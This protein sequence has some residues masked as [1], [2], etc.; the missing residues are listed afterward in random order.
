MVIMNG[1]V[2]DGAQISRHPRTGWEGRPTVRQE[3]D[4]V[5]DRLSEIEK[6]VGTA[7]LHWTYG[8]HD[9]RFNSRL[10]AQVAEFEGVMGMNL[11]DHFPRW[12]FSTSVMVNGSTHIKHR[13]HSGIH[14]V[15]N[16][17]VKAGIS[18]ITGH[19]HSLKVTPWTDMNGTR[20]G[21]DTGSL[22]HPWGDQFHYL[23]DGTRN[24]RSG[25]VVLT[26]HKG[27]LMPPELCEVINE[28]EG[29]AF[30]R[31]TVLKV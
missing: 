13:Q 2:F 10:S 23:E 15:Y 25:F 5:R 17:T 27:K 18:I 3:L 26:F 30:F 31:G 14:A 9:I 24:W 28:E 4:S 11:A 1:D 7:K 29:V 22:A 19:T 6:S 12:K 16:N 21:V 20:Y 8:N